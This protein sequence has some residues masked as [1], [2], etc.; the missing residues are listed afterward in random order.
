MAEIKDVEL[1]DKKNKPATIEVSTVVASGDGPLTAEAFNGQEEP[2]EVIVEQVDD[3]KYKLTFAPPCPAEYSLSIKWG[4]EHIEGSPL[5]L[6]LKTAN[7]KAVTMTQ[8][9]PKNIRPGDK[10]TVR[11][12]VTN[13]GQ[14]RLTSSCSGEKAGEIE[15]KVNRNWSNSDYEVYF[16]P[17]CE[18]YFTLSVKWAG[19]N[20]KGSPL[21]IDVY[22]V[23]SSKVVAS[24]FVVPREPGGKIE[25]DV[26]TKGAG[27][28][29]LKATC[30]GKKVGEIPVKVK[31]E[32]KHD[33]HYTATTASEPDKY[34]FEVTFDDQAITGSPWIANVPPKPVG[35]GIE[36]IPPVEEE[37]DIP[38]FPMTKPY[39]IFFVTEC[40]PNNI[41]SFGIHEE[42]GLNKDLEIGKRRN[43]KVMLTYIAAQPG[44]HTLHVLVDG[45]EVSGS[46]LRVKFVKSDP[47]ACK[48]L[49]VPDVAY[50]G[51]ES[52]FKVDA[53]KA[54]SGE[55]H[56]RAHVP[57]GGSGIATRHEYDNNGFYSIYFTAQIMGEHFFDISWAGEPIF[58]S[59][60]KIAVEQREID[61]QAAKEEANKVHVLNEDLYIFDMILPYTLPAYICIVTGHVG[62]GKLSLRTTGP[63]EAKTSLIDRG[64]G[65]YTA[66]IRPAVAGVYTLGIFWNDV[67]IKGSPFKL[68]FTKDKSYLINGLDL[69]NVQFLINDPYTFHLHCPQDEKRELSITC[70]PTTAA[71]ISCKPFDNDENSYLCEIIP[72]EEGNHEISIKYDG[73]DVHDSPHNVQFDPNPDSVEEPDDHLAPLDI[74]L[75]I[76]TPLSPKEPPSSSDPVP[77]KVRA[78]GPGLSDGMVI[79]QEGS[80]TI[81]TEK[82]GEGKLEVDVHGPKGAFKINMRRHPENSRTLLARYD[83]K[84]VGKYTIDILWDGEHIPQSPFSVDIHDQSQ[85]EN[86]AKVDLTIEL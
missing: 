77:S 31:K 64:N 26:C 1:P 9:P 47:K 16:I 56:V 80:F 25:L 5:K 49:D 37:S 76:S 11:F 39:K 73:A 84:V 79:G 23:R 22:P 27:S 54:G 6:N 85:V 36:P 63:G 2:C 28:A 58:D 82:G 21:L 55:L 52:S 41:R 29:K 61:L 33:F 81:E 62:K 44:I 34:T 42:T 46:P 74:S 12:D 45:N 19:N 66:E 8:A 83:P 15:V 57:P 78:F 51:E 68:H 40:D 48:L 7:S 24:N 14:G 59:P 32:S 13:A 35:L 43:G 86:L 53:R 38:T 50:T 67:H 71:S 60:V 69:D 17:P 20:V 10:V 70:T 65:V 75:D 4:N 3:G 30:K 18:D 72:K